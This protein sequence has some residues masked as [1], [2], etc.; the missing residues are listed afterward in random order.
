MQSG[1]VTPKKGDC[2][3]STATE[4]PVQNPG[5]SC[6]TECRGAEEGL[7]GWVHVHPVFRV[8]HHRMLQCHFQPQK[9]S[10][11]L[12]FAVMLFARELINYL[13]YKNASAPTKWLERASYGETGHGT[14]P[15]L[16]RLLTGVLLLSTR[17]HMV[18]CA[19][20]PSI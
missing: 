20:L 3:T 15:Q 13:A 2:Q 4:S 6:T 17:K 7:A 12:N 11:C 16:S 9:E 18:P 14:S 1:D 5:F 19:L 8:Y 10:V